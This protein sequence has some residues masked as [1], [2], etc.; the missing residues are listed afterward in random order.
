MRWTRRSHRPG[1]VCWIHVRLCY[2]LLECVGSRLLYEPI[3]STLLCTT[4]G[5]SIQS[6]STQNLVP[7]F[8]SQDTQACTTSDH[9]GEGRSPSCSESEAHR[10]IAQPTVGS[11]ERTGESQ[12]LTHQR[13]WQESEDSDEIS[14]P[15]DAGSRHP[16]ID[17]NSYPGETS[18]GDKG[19]SS[20][21][22]KNPSS[23][24]NKASFS[25]DES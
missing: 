2:Y 11:M 23:I 13:V 9:H 4:K 18:I 24:G 8:W 1:V 12:D 20:I 21:G 14:T 15:N 25:I 3:I 10:C 22:D 6:H 17:D 7:D 19:P 5:F 16:S